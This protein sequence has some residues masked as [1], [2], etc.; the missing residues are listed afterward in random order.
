MDHLPNWIL[1]AIVA[2]RA[3]RHPV[4]MLLGCRLLH[5]RNRV[6]VSA[7]GSVSVPSY[8]AAMRAETDHLLRIEGFSGDLVIERQKETGPKFIQAWVTHG[9]Q[10]ILAD[11]AAH[12]VMLAALATER[13][14]K[15]PAALPA[16]GDKNNL[17]G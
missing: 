9:L 1:A 5:Y 13:D 3:A 6:I 2:D 15:G 12:D 14:L 10:K 17:L 16:V 4:L 11:Q 8:R 7:A